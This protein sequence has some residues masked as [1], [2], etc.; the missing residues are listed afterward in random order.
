MFHGLLL[1]A[2][3]PED[4]GEVRVTFTTEDGLMTT[5]NFYAE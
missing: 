4:K 2:V 5:V 1:A 3:M